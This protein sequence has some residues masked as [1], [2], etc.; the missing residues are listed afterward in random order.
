MIRAAGESRKGGRHARHAAH[1][2]ESTCRSGVRP[3]RVPCRCPRQA[4]GRSRLATKV[5]ALYA[6]DY[7]PDDLYEDWATERRE[8]LKQGWV[9]LQIH[10]SQQL[11]QHGDA[12][13]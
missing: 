2:Y 7:L 8:R 11:E 9:E 4:P 3:G 13:A 6:G 5:S 12:E 1:E 10:F